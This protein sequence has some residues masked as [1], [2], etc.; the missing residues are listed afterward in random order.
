MRKGLTC[1]EKFVA[2]H[3]AHIHFKTH[4]DFPMSNYVRTGTTG[5]GVVITLNRPNAL[6]AIN[7][8]MVQNITNV[9]K[10]HANDH[11]SLIILKGSECKGKH[12]FSS[13][14]DV[15]TLVKSIDEFDAELFFS[16]EY[17]MNHQ[18]A[19]YPKPQI[20]FIDGITCNALKVVL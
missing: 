14:G 13:G 15:V 4:M 2:V 6:N 7:F 1:L 9:L 8:E 3:Q 18:I 16:A 11:H 12:V 5:H 17:K 10:S 20:A 19:T